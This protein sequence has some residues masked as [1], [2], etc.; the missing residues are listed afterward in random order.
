MKLIVDKQLI[1][2]AELREAWRGPVEVSLGIEARRAI[3]ESSEYIGEVVDS[4]AEIYGVN[5]GFGQLARVH[6]GDEELVKLQENLVRAPDHTHEGDSAGRR[7]LG[8]A[9]RARGRTVRVDQ[10]RRVS[11]NSGQRLGGRFR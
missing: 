1:T 5:T 10:P 8:R 6:I 7:I 2:L 9:A 11:A 3:A 4:G